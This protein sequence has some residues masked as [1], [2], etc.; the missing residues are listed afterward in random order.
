MIKELEKQNVEYVGF[1]KPITINEIE[2]EI[3][4][5]EN[6]VKQAELRITE[7]KQGVSIAKKRWEE[8][9]KKKK[10]EIEEAAKQ[11]KEKVEEEEE[12]VKE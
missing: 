5:L 1:S 6:A 9:E 3:L 10:E 2:I 4:G 12:E 8:N 7:L 11:P